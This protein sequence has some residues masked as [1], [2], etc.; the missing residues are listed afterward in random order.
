MILVPWYS[1]V[2]KPF[3]EI[4]F[5]FAAVS[6][7]IW[8][9]VAKI[10]HVDTCRRACG[11]DVCLVNCSHCY[12]KVKRKRYTEDTQTCTSQAYYVMVIR[13]TLLN[14]LS[15]GGARPKKKKKNHC[16]GESNQSIYTAKVQKNL[17]SR[18][19][20]LVSHLG[21]S[22]GR[23]AGVTLVSLLTDLLIWIWHETKQWIECGVSSWT[24]TYLTLDNSDSW[25]KM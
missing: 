22:Q 7:K 3:M 23:G 18:Q 15:K 19:T 8:E 4:N 6:F 1:R 17:N 20:E 16:G 5:P 11:L 21:E 13:R 25:H 9:N 24:I 10:N 12:A 2:T 14:K